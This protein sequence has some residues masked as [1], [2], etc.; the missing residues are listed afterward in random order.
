MLCTNFYNNQNF[1]MKIFNHT[2]FYFLILLL[3]PLHSIFANGKYIPTSKNSDVKNEVRLISSDNNNTVISVRVAGYSIVERSVTGENFDAINIEGYTSLG[4]TGQASLPV[5]TKMISIPNFKNVSIKIL[6]SSEKNYSVNKIYPS[7]E[8]PLRNSNAEVKDFSYDK[9]YYTSDKNYPSEI[10]SIKEIAVMRD[11]RV[12]VISINPVRYNPAKNE[13]T[14]Y[15]EIEFELVYDG[16]SNVNNVTNSVYSRSKSFENIY[17]NTIFNYGSINN[18]NTFLIAPKMLILTAD[19]LYNSILPFAEWKNQKGIK[20]TVT[21]RSEINANGNPTSTEIKNYLTANYNSADRTE[22]VLIVGDARGRNTLTWFNATGGKSDH[23]YQCLDGT[24]ILPDIVVGRISVQ[25]VSELDSALASLMQYEK[26]PEMDDTDWYKRALVLH[27]NDG[28]DPINGQVAKSVFL[29]EGGFTNVDIAM[30]S[31]SQNQITSFINGGVSWTWFIGHGNETSWASPVWNMSNMVNLNYENRK[32]TIISI[33]CSNADLDYS[34]TNDCFGEAWIER[35]TKNTAINIAASTE[36]CS[37]YTSDTI[38]REMLY[39]YFRHGIYDFGSMLNFGKIQAYNY[40]NGSGSVI[41]TINQFMVL[42]DPSQEAFSDVPKNIS[43]LRDYSGGQHKFNIKTGSENYNGALI[44][45]SQ[46]SELKSSGYTDSLG[47]YS[48]NSDL[49]N[50]NLPVNI[51][52]TGKNLNP[53][54]GNMILTSISSG[55][56]NPNKFSLNQNYPNPFNPYTIISFSIGN[57]LN[58]SENVILK[59]YDILGNETA[60]LVNE[61]LTSG[62]YSIEWNA[63]NFS[64]GV[65]FYKLSAGNFSEVKKMTLL[66]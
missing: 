43:L 2:F 19:S 57:N 6:N 5:M 49:I 1:S 39:G 58:L 33:A 16:Y 23:P 40:F 17:K 62:S 8:F 42:G 53:Y 46:N 31:T 18:D 52:V 54:F 44:A 63:G 56:E 45:I 50:N 15:D 29:N 4:N 61:R 59:V 25:S 66:K 3:L 41:A 11:H 26:F 22:Y 21:L 32:P 27:S 24:D 37:F 9:N 14:V 34:E 51:V 65:Y 48:F 47:N 55:V 38:G 28:I 10:V 12:A 60:T 7:Q 64:S 20:T 35:S 13:M 36:L 30:E